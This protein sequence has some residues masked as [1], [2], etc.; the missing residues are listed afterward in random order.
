LHWTIA[1]RRLSGLPDLNLYIVQMRQH[2][3]MVAHVEVGPADRAS[4]E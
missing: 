2:L 4:A 1:R 3:G